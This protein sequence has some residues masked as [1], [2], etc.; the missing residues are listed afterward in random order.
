MNRQ[1]RKAGPLRLGNILDGVLADC[2]IDGR[3]SERSL[4]S[5]WGE[6][7]GERVARHVQA[8][9]LRDGVLLLAAAH[10]A[11]RQEVSLLLPEIVAACNA[12]CGAGT[13]REVRWARGW[14]EG[15]PP[16]TDH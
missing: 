2:G 8:V 13:V 3:I 5:A 11:W 14:T 10:A 1:D 12:R 16:A 4:L 7:V 15:A 9:D 6:I